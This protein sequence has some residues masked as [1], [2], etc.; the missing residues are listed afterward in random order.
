LGH[1]REILSEGLKRLAVAEPDVIEKCIY[2]RRKRCLHA[3][4]FVVS[5][6]R[7]EFGRSLLQARLQA[8]AH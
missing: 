3:L 2:R 1:L 5:F 8:L 6:S 7:V 4:L